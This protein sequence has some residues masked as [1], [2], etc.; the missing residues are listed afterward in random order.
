MYVHKNGLPELVSFDHDLADIHY[1]PS[2]WT[3]SFIYK[4]KTGKD[5]AKWLIDYC[6]DNNQKFPK[7]IVH[8]MNTVGK[9]NIIR[10]VENFISS[11]K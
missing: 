6:L 8:S 4:E 9:E 2:T 3:E 7:Y 5:C 10:L 11:Q 1:D